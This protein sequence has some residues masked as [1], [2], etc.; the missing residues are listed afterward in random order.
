MKVTDIGEFE[1]IKRLAASF[2]QKL[3]LGVEGIGDDC[4]VFPGAGPSSFLYTTDL[5]IENIHFKKHWIRPEDLGYKSL[6]VSLS[7]IAGMGGK[8]LYAFLSLALPGDCQ[9]EWLDSFFKGF[10]K[11]AQAENCSLLGGDT[12]SSSGEILISTA[13]IGTILTANIKRRSQA[14][15]HDLICCTGYLGDSGAGLKILT[16]NLPLN[17]VTTPLVHEHVRPRAHLPEGQWLAKQVGVHAMM[18]ISDGITSDIKHIMEE[19]GCGAQ[20]NLDA[21]PLSPSLQDCAKHFS[22]PAPEMA[23]SSGED[24]CLLLTVDPQSYE[25]INAQYQQLFERPLFQ[26]GSITSEHD[27]IFLTDGKAVDLTKM[28]YDHFPKKN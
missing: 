28:G 21:L 14:R 15:V 25:T 8:P 16:D 27:L 7:D 4:A 24:Y 13:V 26:C 23:A 17:S 5:L 9:M 19:S 6:A 3:G 22:W 18:D 20:I 12:S 11:L 10:R 2:D 1:L